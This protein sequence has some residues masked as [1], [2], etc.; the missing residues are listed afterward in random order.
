LITFETLLVLSITRWSGKP[1]GDW[2]GELD[3]EGDT[4]GVLDSE[5]LCEG[6]WL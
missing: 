3:I 1:E 4:D 6:D 5:G 2:D